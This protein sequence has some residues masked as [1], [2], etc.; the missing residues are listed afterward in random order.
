MEL[1]VLS[2]LT[3]QYF[4]TSVAF[5]VM[6]GVIWRYVVP[7]VLAVLDARAAQIASDLDAAASQR[8]EAA[9]QLA[10]YN[11]Q[12]GDARKEAMEIISRARAEAE[13]LTKTRIAA[14]EADLARQA[15]E[16]RQTLEAAKQEALRAVQAEVA[17]LAVQVAEKL[18]QQSLQAGE[19]KLA[20]EL[21]TRALAKGLN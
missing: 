10:S 3:S 21:T 4:Y 14:V 8:G 5:L 18:L 6:L 20:Q 12:M 16:A 15:E 17:K 2:Y 11:A 1:F 7:A 19:T 9:A 13:A